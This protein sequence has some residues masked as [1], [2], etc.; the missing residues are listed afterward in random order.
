MARAA[1]DL[2]R[3]L[4]PFLGT[5]PARAAAQVAGLRLMAGL[6]D[7][8]LARAST[9]L[10][11]RIEIDCV[12]IER[13]PDPLD[14]LGMALVLRV[15]DRREELGIAPRSADV[16]G[17]AAPC[18]VDQE[19]VDEAGHGIRDALDLDRVFPAVAE[20]VEVFQRLR[21]GI[22]EDVEETRLAG[23]ERAFSP[24]RVGHA[25]AHVA[26]P[27]LLEM[28]VGPA[29]GGLEHQVQVIKPDG[30]RHLNAAQH[31]GLDVIE[32][33]LEP[34]D[35]V[36]G[37]AAAFPSL[38]W[39][40]FQGSSSCRREA[41]WSAIRASTSASQAC[42]S[43][44]FSLAVSISEYIAAARSPPRP[45]GSHYASVL[46]G[47]GNRACSDTEYDCRGESHHSHWSRP[48]GAR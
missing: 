32:G 44:S 12:G 45:R 21:A 25:P 42:G 46:S 27:D 4:E 5:H 11:M 6:R 15:G 48:L 16:L 14:H 39:A 17:R 37:H 1:E 20:V 8:A 10:C 31:C 36:A 18:G 33:D 43:T 38:A 26:G 34:D 40:Q 29:H 28:A 23:I 9:A 19:R 30:Q 13:R 41:G 22:L 3:W 47:E 35:A 2:D 24:V 7:H